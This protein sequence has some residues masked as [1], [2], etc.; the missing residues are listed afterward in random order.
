MASRLSGSGAF[1][2]ERSERTTRPGRGTLRGGWVLL[3]VGYPGAGRVPM[4]ARRGPRGDL[5]GVLASYPRYMRTQHH[6]R[7]YRFDR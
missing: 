3:E 4:H 5:P 2:A 7:P 6:L 1:L